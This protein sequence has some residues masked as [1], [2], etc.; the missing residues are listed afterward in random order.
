M[1]ANKT[2]WECPVYTLVSQLDGAQRLVIQGSSDALNDYGL[3]LNLL[4]QWITAQYQIGIYGG[5]VNP[6]PALG[7][8][9]DLYFQTTGQLKQKIG[10]AWLFKCNIPSGGSGAASLVVPFSSA[11][12]LTISNW[13]TDVPA[14]QTASYAALLGNLPPKPSVYI[15]TGVTNQKQ[16]IEANFTY[17]TN[18]DESLILS[19]VID[20]SITQTGKITF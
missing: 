3:P 9:G 1:P 12:N 11:S 10:G 8:N 13:Q 6:D 20:W 16:Q 7:V 18:A 5:A 4:A 2:I 14:G 17:I 19:A 15:H